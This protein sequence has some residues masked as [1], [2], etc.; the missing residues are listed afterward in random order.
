MKT[1]ETG[2][3]A[4]P[5]KRKVGAP[6]NQSCE[7][8]PSCGF[9]GRAHRKRAFPEFGEVSSSQ[10]RSRLN[11]TSESHLQGLPSFYPLIFLLSSFRF[12]S[13]IGLQFTPEESG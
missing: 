10:P 11:T 13:R 3:T 2:R 1:P 8:L 7:R 6:R 4:L 12:Q 5:E 9:I